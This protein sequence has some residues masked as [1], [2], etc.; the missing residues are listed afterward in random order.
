MKRRDFSLACG[1]TLAA[2]TWLMSAAQAQTTTPAQVQGKRPEAG[3]E[4]LPL[5]KPAGVEAPAGKIEVVEFFWYNCPHCNAFEP[6]FEAWSKRAPKDVVIRRVPVAFRSDFGP[7]QRLYYALEAMGLVEQLHAKVFYAI[8]VERKRLDQPE[9]IIN[10]VSQQGVDKA[11]FTD[12]FNAFSTASKATRATQL[13]NAYK[14]E[15][16][17]AMGVAGRFYTDGTMAKG[18]EHVLQVVEYLAGEVRKGR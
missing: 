1:S 9:A 7:Q 4:Y 16:V 17:P 14:V 3:K 13:M 10:W 18:M 15:G 11:K 2:G 5:D 6:T 8:H 12:Q